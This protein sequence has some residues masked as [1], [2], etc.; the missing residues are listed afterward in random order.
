MSKKIKPEQKTFNL[1]P[2]DDKVK[3]A[4]RGVL[5]ESDALQE[6]YDNIDGINH[7]HESLRKVIG[8]V[9]LG[10]KA[11]INQFPKINES[12]IKDKDLL[13]IKVKGLFDNVKT[14]ADE[15]AV[16]NSLKE[17][18]SRC[19]KYDHAEYMRCFTLFGKYTDLS[20][21]ITEITLPLSLDVFKAMDVVSEELKTKTEEC[22]AE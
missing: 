9:T 7:I 12:D 11:A 17:T 13:I 8:E 1:R 16:L 6:L 2:K 10:L 3:N 22:V 21:K 18:L 15:L 20:E 19:E 14:M 4:V 5:A